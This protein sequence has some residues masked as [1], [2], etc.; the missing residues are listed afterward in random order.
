[1]GE[2][3]NKKRGIF[4]YLNPQNL[5]SEINRYGYHFSI[6]DFWKFF[7]GTGVGII[8][9]CYIY[10]QHLINIC[11]V[12][13]FCVFLAP[14]VI[15]QTYKHM[16][17]QKRFLDVSNYLEQ[18]LY[19]FRRVPKIVTA[20][21]DT[22][23]VF[24]EGIMHEMI[25]Q[26]MNHIQH[27]P[28]QE[29]EEIYD[30]AFHELESFYGCRRL[31][32]VHGFLIK[33]EM[34]GGNFN[35]ALDI[36][37]EDRR[38]WMERVYEL[39]KERKNLKVKIVISLVLSFFVCGAT[40]I[41]LPDDFSTMD[42][43]IC[44][45]ATTIFIITDI[46]IGYM[47]QKKLSSNWLNDLYEEEDSIRQAY[48]FVVSYDKRR[49]S[50]RALMKSSAALFILGYGI[51]KQN[52]PIAMMSIMTGLFLF[53]QPG[54]RLRIARKKVMREIDKAFPVWLMELSLLLQT[55]NANVALV[56]SV[57]Q[58]PY[59]L[60]TDLNQLICEIEKNPTKIE[61]YLKFMPWFDLPDA[62][63]A[64]RL[65]Y[66]MAEFGQEDSERQ[67]MGLVERNNRLLDKAER[68][69]DEDRLAGTGTLVLVPMLTGSLKMM[70]DLGVFL[71]SLLS[72]STGG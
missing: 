42:S 44:Q 19:S 15:L 62:Q 17:E 46:L 60:R 40:M 68:L 28:L 10:K 9:I 34:L 32:Q 4:A 70:V 51:M 66:S 55:D 29:G 21:E 49:E 61:P 47:G 24:P 69:G 64:L 31:K 26:A 8:I 33:V 54:L 53:L 59:V 71:M 63:S 1:M 50:K 23:V 30:K 7:V 6:S 36:L 12:L 57:K 18:L 3:N 67:V 5:Q 39:E 45:W 13:G 22:L 25:R 52:I 72:M 48:G 20:L 38:L 56:K 43:G 16:Y 27:K 2:V 11:V 58:A 65:L 14:S 41:M 37:L 35:S